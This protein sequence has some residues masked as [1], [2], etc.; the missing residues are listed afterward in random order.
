MEGQVFTSSA[1]TLRCEK[2]IHA[3]GPKWQGG[4]LQEERTLYACIDNCFDE[5]ENHNLQYLAIPPIST[6][7]FGYPLN[8]AVRTIV[9]VLQDRDR[10]KNFLPKRVAF[11]DNKED[12]LLLFQ[13]QLS[14]RYQPTPQTQV[15]TS[16][17]PVPPRQ[18]TGLSTRA[19][20]NLL[21]KQVI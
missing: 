14:E 9:Q 13:K 2:I 6:G 17:P 12:S 19:Q 18:Q 16:F 15:D 7:I 10:K 4:H 1:G 5:A 21:L 20:G 8:S 11:V 3:V